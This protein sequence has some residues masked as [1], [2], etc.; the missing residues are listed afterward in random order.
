VVKTLIEIALEDLAFGLELTVI[1]MGIIF[2][3]MFGFELM[4]RVVGE[5]WGPKETPSRATAEKKEGE[6]WQEKKR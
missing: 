5:K 2:L 4:I 1:G 3:L 6:P